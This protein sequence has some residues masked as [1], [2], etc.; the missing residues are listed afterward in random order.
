VKVKQFFNKK[1]A[2]IFFLAI[3]A[4]L[5]LP[6]ILSTLKAMLVDKG[7][8]LQTIGFM[9]LVSLPYSIKIFFA[10][11][12]D[13]CAVP[14]LTRF[15]GQRRSWIILTQFFLIILISLLGVAINGGNLFFIATIS[16]AIAFAS[17][18]QDIVIDAYRIELIEEENQGMAAAFYTYGYRVGMLISGAFALFLSEKI[19]WSFVCLILSFVMLIGVFAILFADDT[20]KNWQSKNYNFSNWVKNYVIYP[21]L[22]FTK[23]EQWKI[24]LS[25][26]IFFKLSDVFAGNLTVPFLLII[27]YTKTEIATI[28]KT[29]GLIATL[30]GVF[31]GGIIVKKIGTY[32]SLWIAALA[33]MF[34]N[35]SFAYLAK[36]GHNVD[37]LYFVIFIENFSGGIGDAVFIAYLSALCNVAFS[38]TQ[39]ATLISFATISRSLFSSSAGAVA[40]KLGWYNFFIFSTFL[41]IPGLIFLWILRKNQSR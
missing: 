17:A 32:K 5:P 31:F 38:A 20:R 14:Y 10:P 21:F 15:L 18:S 2:I 25:F 6:L 33:Q 23:R 22:D 27:D 8:N 4:G 1:I 12:I 3:A 39:Y 13:S 40:L 16:F 9:S 35:L 36:I 30:L 7:F 41:A 26:I 28:V 37:A 34:S 24:I 29:F 19:S 11:F